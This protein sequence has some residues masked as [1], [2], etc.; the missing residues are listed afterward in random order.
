MRI[1][2][3]VHGLAARIV[4]VGAACGAEEGTEVTIIKCL[5]CQRH[6]KVIEAITT[7]MLT[8][9]SYTCG[10]CH[11]P[12]TRKCSDCDAQVFIPY[13]RCDNCTAGIF[14]AS[15]QKR[16]EASLEVLPLTLYDREFLKG[17]CI[18][19]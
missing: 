7:G 6:N 2:R 12:I 14:R 10:H 19:I 17:V 4:A 1:G 5:A 16:S 13:I 3:C 8:G 15:L 11:E 9:T 18:A